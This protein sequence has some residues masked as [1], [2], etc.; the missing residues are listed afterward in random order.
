M[1]PFLREPIF[2]PEKPLRIFVFASNN[3]SAIQYLYREDSHYWWSYL[4]TGAFIYKKRAPVLG[5]FAQH[6]VHINDHKNCNAPIPCTVIDWEEHLTQE[7]DNTRDTFFQ[8]ILSRIDTASFDIVVCSGFNIIIPEW[9]LRAVGLPFFNVHPADLS[10]VDEEGKRKYTGTGADAIQKTINDGKKTICSTVHRIDT[11][12]VDMGVIVAHSRPCVINQNETVLAI[13]TR[14]K[15]TCD[16]EALQEA[17]RKITF[18]EFL[19]KNN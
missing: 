19:L 8:K 11:G 13:R 1:K 6:T 16:G 3:A 18:G 10:I 14:L 5:F 9:F 15:L 2:L 7:I 4:I 17:L 12:T